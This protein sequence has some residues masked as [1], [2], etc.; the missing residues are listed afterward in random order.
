MSVWNVGCYHDSR[1]TR[2]M[3]ATDQPP[4]PWTSVMAGDNLLYT[5]SKG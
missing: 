4:V 3:V 5:V 1:D 2:Q